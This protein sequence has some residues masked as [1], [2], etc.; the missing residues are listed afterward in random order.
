ME[1]FHDPAALIFFP[2]VL[3]LLTLASLASVALR[4][5]KGRTPTLANLQ[6]R[7]IAW[8]V[9]IAV[10]TGAL[11]AGRLGA[12]L[13]F[14][15]VSFFALREFATLAPTRRGDHRALFLAFFIALPAQYWL[16]WKGWYNL[17]VIFIPVYAYLVVGLRQALAGDTTD[18]LARAARIQW[19]LWVCVYCVSHIPAMADLVIPGYHGR[20]GLLICW[21]VTVVQISDVLQYVWGKTCGRTKVAPGVSPNKTVE[22]LVGGV[23]SATGVGVLLRFMTPFSA[24]EAAGLGLACTLAGFGGGLVMSAIKRDRGVKDF[25]A[26]LPGHGGMLDRIDSLCFAAPLFFHLVRYGFTD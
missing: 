2:I 3:G 16:V 20:N 24:W 18:F 25:G 21:F 13:L 23:L 11:A 7:T 4:M 22:G 1:I 6:A 5:A 9:M 14:A 8:W 15:G 17:F 26:M 10:F 19:G 12:T